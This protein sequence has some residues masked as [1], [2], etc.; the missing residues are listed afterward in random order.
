MGELQGQWAL[1]FADGNWDGY[2]QELQTEEGRGGRVQ[3]IV[4]EIFVLLDTGFQATSLASAGADVVAEG[5]RRFAAVV[6]VL[7]ANEQWGPGPHLGLGQP[8][9]HVLRW[10]ELWEVGEIGSSDGWETEGWWVGLMA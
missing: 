9:G 7:E 2:L 3:T 5:L 8:Q 6:Q 1:T 4:F 10:A